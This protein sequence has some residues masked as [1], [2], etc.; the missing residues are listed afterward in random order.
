MCGFTLV[1]QVRFSCS[2][3]LSRVVRVLVRSRAV[4]YVPLLLLG[5]QLGIQH[6]VNIDERELL[7]AGY[8]VVDIEL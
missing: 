7:A 4:M 8:E 5:P 2:L 6:A 1:Y 3:A